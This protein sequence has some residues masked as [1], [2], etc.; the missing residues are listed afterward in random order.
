[1]TEQKKTMTMEQVEEEMEEYRRIFD[2]VR[3]IEE[4]TIQMMEEGREEE[5]D[6]EK[7]ACYSFWKKNR[8]C[9]NCISARVLRE[10][11]QRTKLEFVEEDIYQVTACYVEI[12]GKAYVMELVKKL[13][14]E[15]LLD[16]EGCEKLVRKLDGYNQDLY[17]DALTG[18]YNRRYYEERLKE[19]E[20]SAGV[21]VIDLDDFKLWNDTY[22][23]G[24]GDVV[25]QTVVKAIRQS[26]RK[27]DS[28]VRYGGDEFLLDAEGCEKLVRKL[29]GYNQDLYIDALTGSYNR[30]YYEERLK[31]KEISAGVAVIDLDDFKLWNDT[32]G[33]GAGDVVLQTVVKAIR[34]SIR[35]TDSL[36]R[37][38]GD[39]FLLVMPDVSEEVFLK[40]LEYI[41]KQ[42]R[43]A[44]I[45]GF[46]RM[47][48]SVSIGGVTVRQVVMEEAVRKADRLM[49]QAKI[50]KNMVVTERKSIDADGMIHLEEEIKRTKQLIMIVDDSEMNREILA[51]I[52]E[53]DYQIIEAEN[54]EACL[55]LLQKHGT[56][57]SLILLDIVM[58]GM[59]GFQVLHD[60]NK[61][62]WIEDV[63]VIMISSEDSEK[64]IRRA[65]EMG[66]SDYIS[67]PFDAKVVYQRVFNTIKLYAKQRRLIT[68]V[69]D[70]VYEKEKNNRIMVSILSQIVEFR[71]GESGLHVENINKLSGMLLE[72]LVQKTDKY[73]LTWTD[74]YLIT[75][76]SALHDI[77][78]IGIDEKILNKP[79]K[80]TPE[81]FEL[82]KMHTMIGASMLERLEIYKEERLV[83]IACEICRW[84][85]ERYDG[86]GYPDGLKGEEIPIAAQVVSIVDVY[87]ALTS[88]RVYKQAYSHEKAM[89]M[90][91]SGEC[92]AFQP[93]LLDCFCDIQEEVRKMTQEKREKEEKISGFELTDLEETLK[94]SHLIGDLKP[95]KNH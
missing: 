44:D 11:D 88:Q 55:H 90:I 24:A 91:L 66:V 73:H 84:H 39:E 3:L 7:V 42:I 36:V 37:Y 77:G 52:L 4:E 49:Y 34:Q 56:E 26:I 70:Q 67:R 16:A 35:K 85:H 53:E 9:K 1:M 48:L 74:Q 13:N 82:M 79:G 20:T 27:T 64:S 72:R 30:R 19:K 25:L 29:D 28:L 14:E 10:K 61:N 95:E 2:V 23:H 5:I 71:N 76:A 62:H 68:L 81:E 46:S 89:Q 92:G 60:M 50:Q 43:D 83:Q 22:G 87:D 17:I 75:V 80:L 51:S 47:R 57:I 15:F 63:P 12:D 31:E 58:P 94:N 45:P 6:P 8:Q 59:N 18:S 54:G 41:Q 21:A 86:S 78:K 33:H 69:T 32:Y 38:G 40:K 93:L 65:Y